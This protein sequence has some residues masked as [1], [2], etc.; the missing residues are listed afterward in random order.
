MNWSTI[1]RTLVVRTGNSEPRAARHR[2]RND[3]AY[4]A[5]HAAN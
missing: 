1:Y 4:L 2:F 3:T 5:R